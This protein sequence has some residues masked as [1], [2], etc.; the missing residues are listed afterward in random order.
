MVVVLR[1]G[2]VRPPV[3]DASPLGGLRGLGLRLGGSGHEADEGIQ[4]SPSVCRVGSG[5]LSHL[6]V[7]YGYSSCYI[8]LSPNA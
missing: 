2:V 1:E 6:S 4:D 8:E 3:L 5:S 7:P